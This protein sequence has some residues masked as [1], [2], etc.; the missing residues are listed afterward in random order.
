MPRLAAV[1]LYSVLVVRFL[2]G[3]FG[4]S[5]V[6]SELTGSSFNPDCKNNNSSNARL[7]AVLETDTTTLTGR[8]YGLLGAVVLVSLWEAVLVRWEGFSILSFVLLGS[9][10]CFFLVDVLIGV[11][12]VGTRS[13][14]FVCLF[15]PSK[16]RV[17]L[18][19]CSCC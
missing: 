17:V 16:L 5:L 18:P 4:S 14:A 15:E 7:F 12:P 1:L 6:L 10:V 3:V 19:W 2:N 11:L 13:T 8:V 9:A